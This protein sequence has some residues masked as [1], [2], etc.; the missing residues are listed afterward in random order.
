LAIS[1]CFA[2]IG[3]LFAPSLRA[4]WTGLLSIP[5]GIAALLG[6]IIGGVTSESV[7][8]WRGL[9]WGTIPLIL[10]AGGLIAFALPDTAQKVKPK[11]DMSGT[12]MMVAATTT[13]ILGISWLGT[14]ARFWTGALLLPTSLA[15]WIVFIQI[16]MR[17]EAPILDPKVL[18][19]CT[20]AT[21]AVA[22][23]ISFF[24]IVAITGYSTL[25]VQE[26]MAVRPI[27]SGSM[28]TPYSTLVSFM[29]V[30]VGFVLARTRKNPGVYIFA[31]ALVTLALLAMGLFTAGTPIW[32]YVL[33]TGFAG[34]GLGNIPTV[35][36][37]VAQFA[38]P[39]Q[40]IGVAVGAFYFFQMVG[41]SVSPSILG[42]AQSS[43]PSLE[44]GLK[45]VFLV[46]GAVM[47]LALL[48]ILTIPDISLVIERK[49]EPEPDIPVLSTE[50]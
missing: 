28:L 26:V 42:F 18:F 5:V 15:A 1:L 21:A 38:L 31:Y 12:L 44:S 14:P 30:P 17:A 47:A 11:M 35:N 45:I 39:K 33:V 23:L 50:T 36:T 34:V 2:V 16:E 10:I 40:L 41:M 7:L 3:D 46:S 13:R 37:V 22:G 24:G 9:V 43:S 27:I 8:G 32:M 19:N 25:F 48:L 49:D 20:F 6:P 4:K 29:G